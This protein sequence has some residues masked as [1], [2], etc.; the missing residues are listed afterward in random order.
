MFEF[1]A[2]YETSFFA[3]NLIGLNAG[4]TILGNYYDSNFVAH[5]FLRTVDGTMT[6]FDAPNAAP[7]SFFGGTN[8]GSIND[9]G[10]V[11]GFFNDLTQNGA[12]RAFLRASNGTFTIFDTPQAG[13]FA[14]GAS[15]NPSGAVAGNLGEI[16]CNSE[17]LCI[18]TPVSFLRAANGTVSASS[19]PE[20]VQGTQAIGI[21]PAGTIIG[22]HNDANGVAHGFVRNK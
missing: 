13:G 12:L 2:A 7:Y 18:G 20:A 4:G 8:P 3:P 5:G 6:S 10:T 21:N 14:G 16:V 19:D 17:N 15:I 11:A 1:P 22:L 9:S